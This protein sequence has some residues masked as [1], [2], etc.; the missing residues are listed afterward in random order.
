[1]VTFVKMAEPIMMLF[2]L[3]A[4]NGPTDQQVDG[5]PDPPLEGAILGERVAHCKV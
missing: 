2:R 3:W 1:V 5:D 4:Q